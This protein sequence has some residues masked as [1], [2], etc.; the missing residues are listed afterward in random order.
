[1]TNKITWTHLPAKVDKN[2][3][4]AYQS[5]MLHYLKHKVG[6]KNFADLPSQFKLVGYRDDIIEH[7][8]HTISILKEMGIDN[9]LVTIGIIVVHPDYHYPIHIDSANAAR[10]SIGLNI[11]ILNC[12]DSFTA[13]YKVSKIEYEEWPPDYLIGSEAAAYSVMCKEEDA[14]EIARCD[15]NIPHWINVQVPHKPICYHNKIRINSS[16]RFHHS[17]HDL[18]FN[19]YANT[20]L[21]KN[22]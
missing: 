17:V 6:I 19:D 22:D 13:F 20:H 7:C 8:P 3:I 5:E 15:A 14:V 4:S 11:P 2:L 16:I 9:L 1:M 12:A 18:F 10:Q 21:I